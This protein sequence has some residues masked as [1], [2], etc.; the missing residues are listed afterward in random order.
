MR[1]FITGADGFIGSHLTQ[2][3]IESKFKVTALC[4]YN[5]FN[6]LGWLNKYKYNSHKNLNIIS[7]DVRDFKFIENAT[8]K[9][10]IIVHLASLIAIPYSYLATSSYI[11]TNTIGTLNI[12]EAAKKNKV[13]KIIHT[14]TSEVYG[15]AQYVPI[16]EKHPLNGQ[17]P[18]SASKISADQIAYSF[19]CSF[20]L[21]VTTIRPFNT[22]GPRQSNRA[23]IPTIINQLIKKKQYIELGNIKTTRDFNF[24]E[25]TVN[26]FYKVIISE[27][28]KII[29]RTLNIGSGYEI[30]IEELYNL[31]SELVGHKSKIK[32]NNKRL[33][34]LKSE[35]DRLLANN[36]LAKKLI[37]WEPKL[38]GK[39]GLAKGLQTTINWFS[40]YQKNNYTDSNYI[41]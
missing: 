22:Y 23:V 41:Y 9:S 13:K 39:L 31:I 33:R 18:Y 36:K 15:T 24:I 1:I 34:P 40:E 5:S 29:G 30:S 35:V 10:D 25:D 11:Y 26:A 37:G 12:L 28:P 38:N 7:G 17:S 4:Q 6:D 8:K 19:F 21:P 32:T 14:S 27:N 2:R 3:L 20:D 16:D